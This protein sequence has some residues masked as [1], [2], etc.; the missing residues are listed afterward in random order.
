MEQF[1]LQR[2][3]FLAT[4]RCSKIQVISKQKR[5]QPPGDLQEVTGIRY[6]KI[7]ERI[8]VMRRRV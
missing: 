1:D 2:F 8:E 3:T 4:S 7:Q 6:N 5:Y